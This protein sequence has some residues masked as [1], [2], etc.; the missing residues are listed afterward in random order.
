MIVFITKKLADKMKLSPPERAVDDEF[1]TWRANYVQESGFCFVIFMNDASRFNIVINEAKAAKLKKLP[2]LFIE[3]LRDTLLTLGVNPGVADRYIS[4]LGET[5][6]AR[7]SDRKKTVQLNTNTRTVWWALRDYASDTDSSVIANNDIYNTS[8]TDEVIEPKK[9]MLELL[10]QYGL[11]VRKARAY[12][13]N[14]RLDLD[15]KDAV[16]R[17]R[18]PAIM[19]FEQLHKVLQKAFGWKN[20]H[21]YDFGLFKEW[22]ENRYSTPDVELVVESNQYD[23]YETNP[24]AKSMAGVRLCDYLQ[25]YNKILYRY[26]YGDDWHHYIEVEKTIEDCNDSLPILLSGDGDS[27]PDDVGGSGGF[28]EFIEVIA[29]PEHEDYEHLTQ[30]A[31]SQWWRP[32]DFDRMA[33]IIN[34]K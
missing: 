20:Y 6:Y 14:V 19:T 29:D 8:G 28:A 1:L 33:S 21:L 16:R 11:P 25:E 3:V 31:K 9:K 27:P 15:G 7:N 4:E 10:G 12:D 5:T 34:G 22:S 23:A 18:V 2:E 24:N 32:F 26:D 30:W 13:L 17:L